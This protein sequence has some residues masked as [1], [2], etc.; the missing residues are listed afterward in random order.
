M[1]VPKTSSCSESDSFVTTFELRVANGQC[2]HSVL[3]MQYFLKESTKELK[4]FGA[5]H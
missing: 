5:K 4:S 3:L 2:F 1:D